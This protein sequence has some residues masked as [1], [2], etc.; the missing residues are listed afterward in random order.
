NNVLYLIYADKNNS[1]HIA[2]MTYN[3]S[4]W[5]SSHAVNNGVSSST[6]SSA[7]PKA[8]D[9]I[10][11]VTEADGKVTAYYRGKDNGIF[12][13][14]YDPTHN[15]WYGGVSLPR[16]HDDKDVPMTSDSAGSV[17]LSNGVFLAFSGKSSS[18]IRWVRRTDS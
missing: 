18:D 11:A 4:S 16:I 3:G 8:H 10:S 5:S 2:S 13:L 7:Y 1:N 9:N 14:T 12:W 15:V 17:G 6:A